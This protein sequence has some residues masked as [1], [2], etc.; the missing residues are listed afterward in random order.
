MSSTGT[1]ATAFNCMDGRCQEK[2]FTYAKDLF[3]AEHI[4]MI[5]EPGKD[6]LLAG[7][8]SVV[9]DPDELLAR[10]EWIRAKA[11]ISAKGHGSSQAVIF[12]HC[13]CAGNQ[14]SLDEHKEHLRLAKKTVE[15]WG[16]FKEVHTAVFNEE[17]EIEQVD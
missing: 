1:F 12:G 9:T 5:T 6:G 3:N 11:E 17:F 16:L 7:Y 15:G 14:V 2:A 10:V 4:D 8:H 13:Q